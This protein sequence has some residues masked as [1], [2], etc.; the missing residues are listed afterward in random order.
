MNIIRSMT[1]TMV[2]F[3][4]ALEVCLQVALFPVATLV[5]FLLR[6]ELIIPAQHVRHLIYGVVAFGVAKIIVFW[7]MGLH[8]SWWRYLSSYDV[9]RLATANAAG[10]ALGGVFLFAWGPAGFPRSV[11]ILD[12]ILCFGLT[13]SMRLA[14][15]LTRDLVASRGEGKA[16]AVIYGA[17]DAG[18][19][20]AREI[21]QNPALAFR[22]VGFLDDD[23]TKK[24]GV[25][26]GV[27]V[28][29]DGRAL[30]VLA[31]R[32]GVEM[33][34][35][36][37]PSATG[38][39]MTEIL[40]C[41]NGAQ[42]QFKTMPPVGEFIESGGVL[43]QVRDVAVEDLLGRTAVRL[44][45]M[46]ISAKLRG[47][48]V[49]VT[50]AAG[51]IGSELCRQIALF[52]PGRLVG[53]DSGETP[54]FF[55]E[56][57]MRGRWPGVA[58]AGVIGSIQN[59]GR[60]AEVFASY[61][62][63]VVF[64]A[65]AYKHV[66]LMEAHPFEAVENNVFGT[67]TLAACAAASGVEDFVMISSD[68]AVRPTNV[69]GVTKRMAELVVRG[70]QGQGSAAGGTKFVSVRFGNVLGSNGSVIPIFQQQ[71][72]AGGP[73]T[74]TDPEMKRY[75]MTIPEASQL[76]L[77]AATLGRGGEIFVL[78]MGEPV[79]I[80]DLARNLILLSGLRPGVDVQIEYSGV[81]PGE[82]LYEELQME[83]E[84]TVGTAHEKIRVFAGQTLSRDEMQG[85]MGE[86]A[87][88][89][90]TRDVGRLVMAVKMV[91]PDYNPSKEILGRMLAG[92]GMAVGAG[93]ARAL[94][95]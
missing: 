52:G 13:V 42:V 17:G 78:D 62:P 61:R 40:N 23:R 25:I 93:G 45:C 59:A 36:A 65:A 39:Q 51:S 86:L 67:R 33:V 14:A 80:A 30:A 27:K 94:V 32:H 20:L 84:G 47:R 7:V 26:D 64:H 68:K 1:T 41:C 48:T 72:R 24:G 53:V 44:D 88:A 15:R 2:R 85:L 66:P 5:A 57:E 4:R 12:F 8:R 18:V 91:V 56:R 77:Q 19:M 6:F 89:C 71:I 75:F 29:G 43:G 34:F 76:V 46:E 49:L 28:L 10:T 22:V 92:R 31:E 63:E 90:E 50:G 70:M 58:F 11:V 21:R 35:I 54:M 9:L 69:M 83:H 60:M 16:R 82:K 37:I 38:A 73:V 55:L 87:E 3:H 95:N 79:K 74:V 81:R